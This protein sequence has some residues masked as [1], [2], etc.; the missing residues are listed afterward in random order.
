MGKSITDLSSVTAVGLDLAKHVF[1]V[2]AVDASGRVV[3]AKAI[4]RNKLLEFFASLPA[5]QLLAR[6][7]DRSR[8]D[9]RRHQA[10]DDGVG[11]LPKA[12]GDSRRRPTDRP[13]LCRRH[14]RSLAH[15]PITRRRRLS[16]PRSKTIPVRGSR[17]Y[18]RHLKMRGPAGADPAVRGRQRHA[19]PLQGPAQI[20]GLGL[21]HRPAIND[22]QGARRSRA[23][24]C[25]HHAC[26]AARRNRVL[27]GVGPAITEI[28]DRIEL[29]QGATPK[30]GSRRRR[31]FCRTRLTK[32]TAFSTS[33]PGAPLT[34]SSASE[35]A[36]NTGIPRRRK[37]RRASPLTH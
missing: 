32:P 37:P 13:R 19:Y 30:G 31:R 21:R 35:R 9:R 2:H 17:L 11:S 34:P 10:H 3:V 4:R 29:P 5:H 12:H 28:G 22:A 6:G 7:D 24:S 33:P 25:D 36:E 16:G 14:R 23:S 15:P 26:H 20:E 18:R 27:G 8:G 1:Q